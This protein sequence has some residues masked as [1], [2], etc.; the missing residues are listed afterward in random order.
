MKAKREREPAEL[1]GAARRM[2][3][4]LGRRVGEA[5]PVDLQLII[6]LRA[7]LDAAFLAAMRAQHDETGFSYSEIAAGLGTTRQAVQKR[8]REPADD[9][10]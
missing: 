7:E 1:A 2:I 4:A 5:D 6:A 8:L 9:V 3:R 10:A